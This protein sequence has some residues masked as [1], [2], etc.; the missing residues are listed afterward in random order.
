[1][2]STKPG[3]DIP[4]S[5]TGYAEKKK[6]KHSQ[7]LDSDSLTDMQP[8]EM[9]IYFVAWSIFHLF[10]LNWESNDIAGV[11]RKAQPWQ[12]ISVIPGLFPFSH[13]ALLVKGPF[14][15]K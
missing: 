13:K 14:L 9:C 1:M 6:S 4:V 15:G 3:T 12:R 10:H 5:K 8:N 7:I 11:F 2:A